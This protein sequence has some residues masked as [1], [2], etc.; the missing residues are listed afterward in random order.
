MSP[1]VYKDDRGR[2]AIAAWCRRA[3]DQW[4]T[5]HETRILR[6]SL[7]RTSVVV[8][9]GGREAPVLVLPGTN[10]SAAALL[11]FADVLARRRHGQLLLVDLPGQPGLSDPER[12]PDPSAYGRW[13]DEVVGQIDATPIV[14]AHS[15]GAAVALHADPANPRLGPLVLVA[16]AGFVGAHLSFGVLKVTVPWL[17]RPND[18]TARAL[19]ALMA[20]PG[21]AA[22]PRTTDWFRVV[23]RHC[24]AT[25]APAPLTGPQ[26]ARWR[27][28]PIR[29]VL[30]ADDPFFRPDKVLAAARV[31]GLDATRVTTLART[32]HLIPDERPD[33]LVAV[34]RDL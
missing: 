16:P 2:D 6:T 13:L 3:L 9:G 21:H 1:S 12:A 27:G 28:H 14:V 26:L 17:V 32:G 18:D 20:A 15:L 4:R 11:P 33:D 8:A 29:F 5:P 31:A 30:G 10:A 24:R 22:D 25:K 7:G 34:L 19:V 23:G